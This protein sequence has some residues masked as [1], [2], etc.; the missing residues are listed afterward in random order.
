MLSLVLIELQS[1]DQWDN[2]ASMAL[3]LVFVGLLL[4]EQSWRA[5]AADLGHIKTQPFGYS[6]P[7][8]LLFAGIG[9]MVAAG[10]C[11]LQWA[12]H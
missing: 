10:W 7:L 3:M 9:I 12:A 1:P 5:L 8:G 2:G 11:F 6:L 4:A